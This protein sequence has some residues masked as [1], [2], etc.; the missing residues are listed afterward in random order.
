MTPISIVIPCY[1]TGKY[2]PE[3]VESVLQ[4]QH[5]AAEI[6]IVDDGS[7]DE[8]TLRLLDR[9]EQ[10]GIII[11]HTPNRGAPAARNFGVKRAKSPYVLCL[12]SDDVLLPAFLAE[13]SQRLD[14][15]PKVGV[16]ATGVEFFG[17]RNGIWKPPD[18]SPVRM[19]WQNCLPSASL[20]RKRCWQEVGGYK[21]LKA[22]QDWEFWISVTIKHGWKWAVVPEVLYK[23]RQ[24]AGSISEF[25]E[26]NRP[27]LMK[28]IIKLH[29]STYNSY[30]V[31]LL[32]DSHARCQAALD[33][34]RQ[35]SEKHHNS[36]RMLEGIRKIMS[37]DPLQSANTNS[38]NAAATRNG[39][40]PGLPENEKNEQ[41]PRP[42]EHLAL[43][44][45]LREVVQSTLPWQANIL[46]VSDGEQELLP[47]GRLFSQNEN[48]RPAS[49]EA[50]DGDEA[51]DRLEKLR[52][53]GAEFLIVPEPFFK[54]L[55]SRTAFNRYLAHRYRVVCR[56]EDTCVILDLRQPMEQ[57]TFSVVI[58]TYRRDRFLGQAIE[59]IFAQNYP[60]DKY[61]IIVINNDSPDNTE[62]VIRR[63]AA[64]SPV[65]F[66]SYVEKRNG[67][68][69][70]RNLGIANA[71]HE[72]VAFLDDDATACT[73]WLAAFNAVINEHHALVVGGRVEKAF[74][75]GFTPPKW[76]NNQYMRGFFGVNY[77]DRGRKEKV[78]R[79]R[80]PLYIG[81]GN[82]AY[83][84]RLFDHFGGFD[85]CLGRDG[86]TLL[87]G[88]ETYFNW[89]LDRNDIPIYYCDDAYIN[90][91][92]EPFRLTKAHLRRKAWWS[93]I[94][95]ATL[96]PML[97]GYDATR[98]KA[99]SNWK[100]IWEKTRQMLRHPNDPE[101]FSRVCRVIYNLSFL[102]KFY[103]A[104]LKQGRKRER[105]TV[106]PI[107]WNTAHRIAEVSRWPEGPDKNRE[108]Y[109]YHLFHEDKENAQK[110]LSDLAA[111]F[112]FDNLDQAA[113]LLESG[114]VMSQRQHYAAHKQ[115][116][117]RIA[118]TYLPTKA[119][120]LVI[121]KGDDE[122]LQFEDRTGW[123]F[124]QTRKNVYAGH[125]PVDSAGAITHLE[126]LRKQ[127]ADFLLFPRTAFW[128]LDHY[129]DFKM[130]LSSR[131]DLVAQPNNDC[132]IFDLRSS[133]HRKAN[134]PSSTTSV[135]ATAPALAEPKVDTR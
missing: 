124:P 128:W 60:K 53:E 55:D 50:N 90:H 129:A 78:F 127:G 108:L 89:V 115:E 135:E 25:R 106:L 73:D 17:A 100:E 18:Y 79:I 121:S 118:N 85:P 114:T 15:M 24:R 116:L 37:G 26:T 32:V 80:H 49:H 105:E 72:F 4:Q 16:V 11:F 120:V 7:T 34:A 122:L 54:W 99:K 44:K 75:P 71:R 58:C 41:V 36:M 125:Y 98:Q 1:N 107:I 109:Y 69:F 134:G 14:T 46:L 77:R 126:A 51:I 42:S 8:E 3:A 111:Y 39:T 45:R 65:T 91:F 5:P 62:E 93:G 59:S 22:C 20:F 112:G 110:V 68:S 70:A 117:R 35:Y 81:G 48:G 43:I 29:K 2:L 113:R 95:N 28:Q 21:N 30:L 83:A 123:H 97:F 87:A 52:D 64:Q 94:T 61:E 40:L 23:Y 63:C 101:N 9:Y 132:L 57:H 96:N 104:Y 119:K 133:V 76:F 92:I 27:E 102:R 31:E 19:L 74:E 103:A 131:Y 13:T 38:Q 66:S 88:E 12:D 82:C 33:N 56:R 67:L 47:T 10:Q 6:I 130:H 86:K 84:R